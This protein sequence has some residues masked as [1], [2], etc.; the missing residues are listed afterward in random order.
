MTTTHDAISQS[1]PPR[2]PHGHLGLPLHL[3]HGDL[4]TTFTCSNLF[5]WVDSLQIN[6]SRV[7]E[8]KGL[9]FSAFRE[10]KRLHVVTPKCSGSAD[11]NT[12][13]S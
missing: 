9:F 3:P 10:L 5:N 12:A 8:G 6:G 4:P 7:R 11:H 1:Q 13:S 2:P